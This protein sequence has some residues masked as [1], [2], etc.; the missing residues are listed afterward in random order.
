MSLPADKFQ[1]IKLQALRCDVHHLIAPSW[2][3]GHYLPVACQKIIGLAKVP[4]YV[5]S[6]QWLLS[7][8]FNNN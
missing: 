7:D 5:H 3:K 1:K 2:I 8:L 6:R 4:S